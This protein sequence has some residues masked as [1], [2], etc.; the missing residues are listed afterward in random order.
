[1]L[2]T[3]RSMK[4]A[5]AAPAFANVIFH[6]LA[7]RYKVVLENISHHTGKQLKRVFIVGGGSRN[8]YLNRLI[9][10]RTGMDVHTGSAESS[11]IGNFAI[12]LAVLDGF[13]GPSAEVVARHA[14]ELADTPI[15]SA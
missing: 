6:S 12:Q 5:D 3:P 10:E 1:M 9:A 7:A 14:V 13:A 4:S 2:V 15:Q 11:T 8:Q